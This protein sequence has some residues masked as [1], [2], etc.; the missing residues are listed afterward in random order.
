MDLRMEKEEGKLKKSI[1]KHA[2]WVN[3]VNIQDSGEGLINLWG[4]E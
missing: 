1:W 3:Q 2:N 4:V